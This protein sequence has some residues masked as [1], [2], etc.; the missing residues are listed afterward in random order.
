MPC[1]AILRRRARSNKAAAAIYLQVPSIS[2]A[3]YKGMMDGQ[4]DLW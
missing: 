1:C 4:Y 3:S 2:P